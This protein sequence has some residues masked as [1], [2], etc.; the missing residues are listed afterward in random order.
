MEYIESFFSQLGGL[1]GLGIFAAGLGVAYSQFRSG[2]NKVKDELI[3]TLKET[4]LAEKIKADRLTSDK[5]TLE[6]S[7]Q[8]QLTDLTK[9]MGRLQGL[10]DAAEKRNKEMMEILQGKDPEMIEILNEIKVF[11][12]SLNEKAKTN[13]ERNDRVDNGP[14]HNMTK[15]VTN[16]EEKSETNEARN[17]KMDSELPVV[18]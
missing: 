3:A 13:E 5:L 8:K 4:A 2:S 10:Y 15:M 6:N 11:M 7:H 9:E 17:I 14:A 12:K 16:I 18:Q 1:G